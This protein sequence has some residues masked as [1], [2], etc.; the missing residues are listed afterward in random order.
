MKPK[1]CKIVE[2]YIIKKK[3]AHLLIELVRL[4]CGTKTS[5]LSNG[6]RLGGV[7]GSVRTSGVGINSRQFT[8]AVRID[9][10]QIDTLG[11]AFF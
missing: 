5:V 10:L 9:W 4:F 7:H 8:L 2:N 1:R 3:N 6:P 11:S